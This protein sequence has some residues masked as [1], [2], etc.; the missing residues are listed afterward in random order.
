[1][2]SAGKDEF[3]AYKEHRIGDL[4]FTHST[5]QDHHPSFSRGARQFI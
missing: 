4:M 3:D 5:T 1:V 2:D